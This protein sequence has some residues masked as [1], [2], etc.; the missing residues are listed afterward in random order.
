MARIRKSLQDTKKL[1]W[2]IALYIRLSK[3]DGND[4][5]LSVE[6]QRKI[7]LDYATE[8]FE[9]VEFSVFDIYVD[10]GL[11][12][13]DTQRKNFMRMQQDI[14]DGKVNCVIVKSLARAFR[15]LADQQKFLEEFLPLYGVRFINLGSPFIDTYKN[16]KSASGLEV[17]I[18]GMFNEQ[19]AAQTSEEI[20]KTFDMKRSRGEFIGS[21]APYG[22]KKDPENKNKLIVDEEVAPVV[23]DIFT[24][25]LYSTGA[26]NASGSLSIAGIARELNERKIPSPIAYKKQQ[27]YRYKSPHDKFSENLWSGPTISHIL[28]NRVYIGCMVQGRQRVISYKIH[29]LVAMPE[30]E[31]FIKEG[32]HEAIISAEMFENVQKRFLRD[33]R[34]APKSKEVHIFSGFL[35]CADCGRAM[36]RKSRN[37]LVYYFCRTKNHAP[38]VCAPRSIREDVLTKTI[39]HAIQAQVALICELEHTLSKIN[40]AKTKN[41]PTSRLDNLLEKHSGELAKITSITDELYHDWK[42]EDI[43]REEYLRMKGTYSKQVEQL[44]RA[45]QKLEA[46]KKNLQEGFSPEN[47]YFKSFQKYGSITAL[48]RDLLIDL[49]DYISIHQD[50]TVEIKFNFADQYQSILDY[51]QKHKNTLVG[52]IA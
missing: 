16:P 11:T 37:E 14:I 5:S 12:G 3:E 32:T 21:F 36:H 8:N 51:I 48:R 44:N 19:F 39:L 47:S 43:T 20:R 33:T 10:D 38:R 25:Y 45:I 17:P 49:I 40:Q 28:K 27:G 46:E 41:D 42:T 22:Y 4:E 52:E 2:N 7:L 1:I 26:N 13:T 18:R 9:D 24:W 29:K 34:T 15:N 6:N 31:W 30:N 50:K 35:R 23:Q